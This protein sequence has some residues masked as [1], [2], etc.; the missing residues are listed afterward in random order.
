MPD[1]FSHQRYDEEYRPC[2]R[3]LSL[4]YSSC[5][6]WRDEDSKQIKIAHD[7]NGIVTAIQ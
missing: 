6:G 7:F 4:K 5:L 3:N 2:P 1:G